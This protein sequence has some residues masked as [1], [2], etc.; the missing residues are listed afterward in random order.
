MR[1]IVGE[2][3]FPCPFTHSK[4][5]IIAGVA[6]VSTRLQVHS[7]ADKFPTLVVNSQR[8]L[9]LNII[10]A[11]CMLYRY[12]YFQRLVTQDKTAHSPLPN[13][14]VIQELH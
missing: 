13:V 6:F 10:A 14:F 3:Y 4:V 7:S 8:P 12:P 2:V 9:A 11:S 1:K 5:R